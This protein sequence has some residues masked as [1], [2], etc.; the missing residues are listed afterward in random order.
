MIRPGSSLSSLASLAPSPWLPDKSGPDTTASGALAKANGS[1]TMDGF[2]FAVEGKN[3]RREYIRFQS[4]TPE[5]YRWGARQDLLIDGRGARGG[6]SV[7]SKMEAPGGNQ[8][9][10]ADHNRPVHGRQDGL[11]HRWGRSTIP[12][13]PCSPPA[14][15]T[16]LL[17][18]LGKVPA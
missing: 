4:K 1:Q 16:V 14:L 11:R 18:L 15:V 6:C 13:R 10:R 17:H 3:T 2:K 5:G 8:I 7:A 12:P 9:R